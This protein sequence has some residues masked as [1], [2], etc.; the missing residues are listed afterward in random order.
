MTCATNARIAGF[1]F[2]FYI[3]VGMTSMY[4]FDRATSAEGTAATL[5]R[6][7]ENATEMRV[8]IV[9]ELLQ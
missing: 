3:A 8:I 7:A 2:L 5:A 6:I 9:L 4:L 1:T